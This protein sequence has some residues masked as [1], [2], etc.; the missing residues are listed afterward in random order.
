MSIQRPAEVAR[1]WLFVPGDRPERFAKATAAGA[2]IVVLDLEDAVAPGQKAAARAHVT[3]WLAAA[4]GPCAVRINGVRTAWHAEDLAAIARLPNSRPVLVML[5]KAEDPTATT[6]V[7]DALPT[8]SAVVALVE[9]ALGVTQAADLARLPGVARLAF[10]SYDFASQLGVDP[11]HAPA[12]AAARAGVVLA[13]AVGGLAGPIDGVTGDVRDT[14]RLKAD[15]NAAIALGFAGKLCIHPAQVAPATAAMAPSD[16][17]VAWARRV[18]TAL[19]GP[20]QAVALVDGRMVDAPVI[21]RARRIV[22]LSG[23]TRGGTP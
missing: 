19:D 7:V 2:D 11:E 20:D 18:V 3:E 8:G 9:T 13:S 22:S 21:A 5:A 15:V 16:K 4:P 1:T 10:G 6:A 23:L 14:D 12:L 17:D